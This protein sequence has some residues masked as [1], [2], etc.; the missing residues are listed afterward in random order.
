M[1]DQAFD[2]PPVP[3]WDEDGIDAVE[4]DVSGRIIDFLDPAVTRAATLEE[5]VRQRF[6]RA[7]VEEYGYTKD[8][9]ALNAPIEIGSET[10]FADI[11]V[12]GTAEARA[13][14][15]QGHIRIVVETKAPTK[16]VGR[17]QLTSYIFASSAEGGVWTNG[18]Q[19]AYFRRVEV[20]DAH[21]EEWT[22]IPRNGESWDTVG[23][24]RKSDL[25][26][27]RNLKQVFR[28]C[29][30]AI[31]RAGLDS[32]DVAVD[33]VRI[34][35]AKY[36]DESKPGDVCEF[37]CTPEEYATTEGRRKVRDRVCALFQQVTD[38]YPGVFAPREQITIA[39][40]GL[41][42]VVNE[43]QPFKFL[44]GDEGEEVYD[45]IGTAFEV[46][47]A[48]HLK[49][50]RGQYFTNRLVANLM[51]E[52]VDPDEDDIVLDPGCG[53]AGFLIA[54]LRHIRRKIFAS[55]RSATAKSREIRKVE[56]RL[57]G[58]DISHKLVRVED[59]HDP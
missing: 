24:Y 27:P 12:Y 32:E 37:R 9:I 59:K 44:A 21:L 13:S 47:V 33:M 40:D 25:K 50:S 31:Y 56:Q 55:N 20:P 38:D 30:N 54:A 41:A 52:I 39:E 5:R 15:D 22:N 10:R 53:S 29:H 34:I 58:I 46:Y 6:A 43:L 2:A 16:S 28:R 26:P 1:T 4:L 14:R 45:V 7:L 48:A 11:V 35:L 17:G 36:K 8:C 19:V 3:A 42:T 51:V 49:G 18:D 57:F 23:K